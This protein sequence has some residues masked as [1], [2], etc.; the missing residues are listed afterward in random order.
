MRYWWLA[1]WQAR[2]KSLLSSMTCRRYSSAGISNGTPRTRLGGEVGGRASRGRLHR[3]SARLLAEEQSGRHSTSL[4]LGVVA[5]APGP[6]CVLVGPLGALSQAESAVEQGDG[7]RWLRAIR[8]G[9]TDSSRFFGD[10]VSATI[11]FGDGGRHLSPARWAVS[12]RDSQ[13]F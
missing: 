6:P 3:E 1:W 7:R 12:G 8:R 9:D 4:A 11:Q 10:R 5:E 13:R 2:R